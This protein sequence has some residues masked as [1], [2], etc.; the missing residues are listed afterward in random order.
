[1][2]EEAIAF[3]PLEEQLRRRAKARLLEDRLQVNAAFCGQP[4]SRELESLA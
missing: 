2:F 4:A 3:E 1:M